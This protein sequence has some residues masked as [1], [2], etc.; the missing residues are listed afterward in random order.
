[1]RAWVS[2]VPGDDL[3][4]LG[5]EATAYRLSGEVDESQVRGLADALGLEGDVQSDDAGSWWVDGGGTGRLDVHAGS[6]ATWSFFAGE[7]DCVTEDGSVGGCCAPG[8]ACKTFS[9]TGTAIEGS[10]GGGSPGCPDGAASDCI[11]PTT[12]TVVCQ[13][14]DGPGECQVPP[15]DECDQPNVLCLCA[16]SEEGKTVTSGDAANGP[17]PECESPPAVPCPGG[18]CTDADCAR[19]NDP[20]CPDDTTAELPRSLV[21]TRLATRRSRSWPPLAPTW[22]VR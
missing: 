1:M 16:A 18:G 3:P 20:T 5:G 22:T 9:S 21:R 12:T 7:R 19:A 8:E 10:A 2:Y 13:A 11:G 17:A 14:T 15:P 4:A 6:G